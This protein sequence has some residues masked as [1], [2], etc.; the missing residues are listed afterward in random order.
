MEIL[1][2]AGF[3]PIVADPAEGRAFYRDAEEDVANGHQL[4]HETRTEP[5]GRSSPGCSAPRGSSS[6]SAARPGSTT[7]ERPAPRRIWR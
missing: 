2:V 4:L 7:T 6:A 1:F 5:W 3:S